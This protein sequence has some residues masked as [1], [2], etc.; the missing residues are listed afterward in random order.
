MIAECEGKEDAPL[1]S[2]SLA[3]I[4]SHCRTS[5]LNPKVGTTIDEDP[6]CMKC[7]VEGVKSLALGQMVAVCPQCHRKL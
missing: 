4:C 3:S 2:E 6:F 7:G 1:I 5:L